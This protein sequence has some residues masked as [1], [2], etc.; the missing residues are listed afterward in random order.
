MEKARIAEAVVLV[1]V[2]LYSLSCLI[3]TMK[4]DWKVHN[5]KHG[6]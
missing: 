1:P 4:T 2:E 5:E 6:P 3:S